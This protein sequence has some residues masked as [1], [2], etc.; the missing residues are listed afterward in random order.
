MKQ[1]AGVKKRTAAGE[2]VSR[3]AGLFGSKRRAQSAAQGAGDGEKLPWYK[4]EWFRTVLYIVLS[5]LIA[6][7]LWGYVLMSQNPARIKTYTGVTPTFEAGGEA[8]LIAKKLIVYGDI[9][10]I[11]KDVTVT[12]SAPLRNISKVTAKDIAAT[13]SLADVRAAGTYDLEV[14]AVCSGGTVVSV[15]PSTVSVVI[16]DLASRSVPVTYAFSGELPEGY[17]HGEPTLL[18]ATTTLEGARG[19]L[20]NVSKA[21]C[22]IDLENVTES[23]NRSIQ[24]TLLDNDGNEVDLAGLKTIIPAVDVKMTV[25]P[26]RHVTVE[27]EIADRDSLSAL[28]EITGEKLTYPSLD[29]AAEP[30]VLASITSIDSD[31]VIIG[32]ITDTGSYSFT[33][34]LKGIPEGAVILGGVNA[35]DIQLQLIVSERYS[36][37][38]FERVPISFVGETSDYVYGHSMENVDVTVRGPVKLLQSFLSSDLTVIVNVE[39]RGPGAYDLDLEY[40]LSDVDKYGELEITLAATKVHVVVKPPNS[41]K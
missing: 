4:R 40:T 25:L 22:Y 3:M 13:V 23:V 16:D 30:D 29:I 8:D 27:Y 14:K 21:V 10:E 11:L 1:E 28:F 31:P 37:Q 5:L 35:N 20:A 33:L 38:V 9:E 18:D 26:H 36:E 6:M 15:E 24:L 34:T 17:W 39:G 2:I 41:F 19:V 32:G 12:V 7:L